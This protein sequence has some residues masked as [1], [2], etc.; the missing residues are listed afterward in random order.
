M[1]LICNNIKLKMKLNAST[2]VKGEINDYKNIK[3]KSFKSLKPLYMPNIR[4]QILF[5]RTINLYNNLR[6]NS[7]NYNSNFYNNSLIIDNYKKKNYLNNSSSHKKNNSNK[8]KISNIK[9]INNRSIISKII[10]LND[11]NALYINKNNSRKNILYNDLLKLNS[12]N[13]ISS[14]N[15]FN[16]SSSSSSMDKKSQTNNFFYIKKNIKC[17]KPKY[18]LNDSSNNNEY[19]IKMNEKIGII[20]NKRTKKFKLLNKSEKK[21]RYFKWFI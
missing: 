8:K 15:A 9:L 11:I 5:Q 6:N 19:I 13:L 20:N 10:P 12:F 3:F 4:S 16:I 21:I 17:I 2:L 7:K 18:L 14:N 1:I